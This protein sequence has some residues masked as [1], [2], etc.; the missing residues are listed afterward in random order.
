MSTFTFSA[1]VG[2]VVVADYRPMQSRTIDHAKR[3]G[4]LILAQLALEHVPAGE[5][6][7]SIELFNGTG[8]PVSELR[9]SYQEIEKQPDALARVD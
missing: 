6:M 3:E 2:A 1:I 9:L 7:I 5:E 8:N 4:R